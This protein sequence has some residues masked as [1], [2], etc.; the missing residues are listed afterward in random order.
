MP[1]AISDVRE[2]VG[3]GLI[4]SVLLDEP[5]TSGKL[6]PADSGAGLPPAIPPGMRAIGVKV[7]DVIGVAGFVTP[8][9]RVDLVVTIRGEGGNG[10]ARTVASNVEVLT[11]GTRQQQVNPEAQEKQD[12][13]SVVTLLVT[14]DDAE[15]IAL[16]QAEGQIMLVL[17]NGQDTAPTTTAGVRTRSLL[18][19][20][21][22]AVQQVETPKPAPA[23]RRVVA[24]ATVEAPPPPPARPVVE[25]IR[26][27]KKSEEVIK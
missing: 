2:A 25:T 11:E 4:A 12:A 13:T 18:G 27:G 8:G 15:R 16:A 9:S 5:I 6:A 22:P 17:R 23:R 10:M 3:R 7:N 1:G 19:P 20:A 26:A 21:E 24:P 14:P